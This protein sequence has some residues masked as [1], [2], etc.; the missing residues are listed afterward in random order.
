MGLLRSRRQWVTYP[1]IQG[2]D[3]VHTHFCVDPQS[4]RCRIG[5]MFMNINTYHQGRGVHQLVDNKHKTHGE[6]ERLPQSL[7]ATMTFPS[8]HYYAVI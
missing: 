4:Y 1:V 5:F 6:H 2:M 3:H 8:Q 7:S